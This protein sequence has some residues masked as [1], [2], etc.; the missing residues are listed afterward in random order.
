MIVIAIVYLFFIDFLVPE[1]AWL[2]DS[3]TYSIFFLFFL[4]LA[5]MFNLSES[6]FIAE[7]KS[8]YVFSKNLVWSI[9]KVS[10]PFFFLFGA[11]GIFS[12]WGV[13]VLLSLVVAL[14][15]MKFVPKVHINWKLLRKM[16]K[17]SA[18][19]YFANLTLMLPFMGLPIF[20]TILL[21]AE[22]TGYFYIP[23]M[24]A[25]TM[26]MVPQ[27]VGKV[28]LSE[29]VREKKR[30]VLKKAFKFNYVILVPA[31]IILLLIGEYLL[32][33][34]GA[35]YV[36]NSLVIL[37][38][39]LMSS[40]IFAV[41]NIMSMYYNIEH[42]VERIVILNGVLALATFVFAYIFIAQGLEI[43]GVAMAWLIANGLTVM[44]L[45]F[46]QKKLV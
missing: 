39:L 35:N 26:F 37:P 43:V 38:V 1:L 18:A 42:K 28:L 3:L 14:V 20:V 16:M 31:V 4:A 13:S 34:F 25:I 12:A 33:A 2:N 29:G 21:G 32:L 8:K 30:E 24:I 22:A 36:E 19:N 7:R 45:P 44:V 10:L 9:A 23:W 46:F 11:F 41:H 15:L 40:L 5:P 27:A 17:F 6:V